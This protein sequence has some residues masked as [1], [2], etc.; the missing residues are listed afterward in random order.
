[1]AKKAAGSAEPE[2]VHIVEFYSKDYKRLEAVR[3][4]PD[5]SVVIITG[6]NGAGKTSVMDA[7]SEVIGGKDFKSAMPVRKGQRTGFVSVDLGTLKVQRTFTVEDDGETTSTLLIENQDGT[8]PKSPQAILDELA[9]KLT[10]DPLEFMRA[11]PAKRVDIIKALVPAF[12]FAL[13]TKARKAAFEERTQVN[14]DLRN[15]QGERREIQLPAGAKPTKVSTSEFTERL[16]AAQLANEVLAKRRANREAAENKIDQLLDEATA[17]R[18]RATAMESEAADLAN[19]LATAEP[20]PAPV[21]TAPILAGIAVNE[22]RDVLIRLFER[23]E[24]ADGAIEKLADEAKALTARI[25]SLDQAKLA[26][27]SGAALPVPG[28]EFND[29]DVLLNA[30]PF[31]QASAAE[32][33]RVSTAIAMALKPTL[34]VILIRDG[35]L[36][37]ANGMAFMAEIAMQNNF[38]IWIERVSTGERTGILIE[39]GK[40]AP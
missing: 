29:E 38:Q 32:Q 4:R 9:G 18:V 35:S 8:R 34:R 23:A 2:A 14:R 33:L 37:D 40:V 31:E 10:L 11:A 3:I 17:L 20:L 15:R 12:D 30:V 26:A 16:K 5:G 36:L 22:E 13:N 27:I 25:D 39:D 1:M 19:K 6:E 24:Q 7:I 28:I 21:D